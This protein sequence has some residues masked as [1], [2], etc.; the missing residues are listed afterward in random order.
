MLPTSIT[1]MM[2]NP[3]IKILKLLFNFRQKWRFNFVKGFQI[4]DD[5]C[6][7][8]CSPTN[9]QTILKN[10]GHPSTIFSQCVDIIYIPSFSFIFFP[11][12]VYSLKCALAISLEYKLCTMTSSIRENQKI[13]KHMFE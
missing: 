5:G 2:K 9:S 1:E 4:Y 10:C 12:L 13:A 6:I 11:S 7:H 8:F 3:P